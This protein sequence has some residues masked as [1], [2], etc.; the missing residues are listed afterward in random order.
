MV[1]ELIERYQRE[2]LPHKHQ[3]TI[4]AQ[5]LQLQWW[6]QERG[7]YTLANISPALLVTYR[8]TLAEGHA[9]ATVNRYATGI[10]A[11]LGEAADGQR[12]GA[13]VDTAV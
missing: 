2:V 7:D 5:Q 1:K 13:E 6:Q 4:P 11:T 8:N 9:N 10:I 3:S 12:T